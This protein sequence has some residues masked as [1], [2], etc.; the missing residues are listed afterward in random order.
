MRTLGKC[1]GEIGGL[2]KLVTLTMKPV[3]FD[4]GESELFKISTVVV[5]VGFGKTGSSTSIR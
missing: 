5:V 3:E 2:W 1:D 4:G